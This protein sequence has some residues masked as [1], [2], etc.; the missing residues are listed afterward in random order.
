MGP[1]MSNTIVNRK[2]YSTVSVSV[3]V[4]GSV[5]APDVAFICLFIILAVVLRL[6]FWMYTDRIW[7]DALITL[8]P[9]L[10]LWE[11]HGLTHHVAEPRVYSF[12]SGLSIMV[13][14][15]GEGLGHPI[16][17]NRILSLIAAA[18]TIFF[19]ARIMDRAGLNRFGQSVCLSYLSTDHL[20]IFFGMGG[21]ETQCAVAIGLGVVYA[22]TFKKNLLL[23]IMGGLAALA[24]P[25]FLLLDAVFIAYAIAAWRRKAIPS[26]A[27]GLAIFLPWVVFTWIYYG[28]PIPNT[29]T[30]K[31]LTTGNPTPEMMIGYALNF[32]KLIAPFKEFWFVQHSPGPSFFPGLVVTAVF[33]MGVIG[34]ACCG[35]KRIPTLMATAVVVVVFCAYMIRYNVHT[36]FMWYRPPFWA[37]FFLFVAAGVDW[38]SKKNRLGAGVVGGLIIFGYAVHLPFTLNLDRTVQYDVEFAV[39]DRIGLDLSRIM[40]TGD[41]VF[42][43]PLGYIGVR[44]RAYQIYDMPGLGSKIAAKAIA[45]HGWGAIKTLDPTYLVLR[46]QEISRLESEYPGVMDRYTEVDHVIGPTGTRTAFG[47]LVYIVGDNE[48]YIFKRK[49]PA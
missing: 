39:R 26:I 10:N 19:A 25:E 33:L 44:N 38:L 17:F 24:R 1:K 35:Q 3:S 27:I 46:P 13:L 49:S 43:E 4:S 40:K 20:Q 45:A 41:S 31:S 5:P 2:Q 28:S 7:E 47:G 6:I 37:L 32:W 21:M 30:V 16:A 29:I 8:N 15:V 18:L 11:G 14:I 48:F 23:G 22:A 42:L 9:A 34:I 12:T 36:Y